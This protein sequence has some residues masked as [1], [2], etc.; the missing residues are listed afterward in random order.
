MFRGFRGFRGL[1]GLGLKVE[2]L[3][4]FGL[5]ALGF[6]GLKKIPC[7]VQGFRVF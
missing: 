4:V 6:Q 3:G 2:L 1:G 7:L 5:R